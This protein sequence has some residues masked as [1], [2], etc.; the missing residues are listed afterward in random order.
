[1]DLEK[2]KEELKNIRDEY[3]KISGKMSNK[4]FDEIVGLI[5][6]RKVKDI[7]NDYFRRFNTTKIE[8]TEEYKKLIDEGEKLGLLKHYKIKSN[9][10]KFLDKFDKK[11]SVN[12]P[13]EDCRNTVKPFDLEKQQLLSSILNPFDIARPFKITDDKFI[14]YSDIGHKHFRLNV[15]DQVQT[16][17]QE[18]VDSN[19]SIQ[20]K[21]SILKDYISTMYRDVYNTNNINRIRV[22]QNKSTIYDFI[23]PEFKLNI[24]E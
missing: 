6:R 4:S 16:K 19:E 12:L 11:P 18:L 3:F 5:E 20:F 9:Y 13:S 17:I 15:S 8:N 1:M 22:K 21:K 7:H 14:I 24:N 2:K 10:C 23:Y